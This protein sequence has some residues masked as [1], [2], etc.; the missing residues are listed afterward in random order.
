[1]IVRMF[2]YDV[3]IALKDYADLVIIMRNVIDAILAK[4]PLTKKEVNNIML[5]EVF[6]LP[7]DELR[8][9]G[10]RNGIQKGIQ[11]GVQE[12]LLS[13]LRNLMKNMSWTA[14][15]AMEA[16]SIPTAEQATYAAML[17]A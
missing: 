5:G 15:Q 10:E 9:E 2:E 16:L 6:R 1:M 8:E 12:C 11:K 4:E 14:T 3:A 17:K 13:S 7:S